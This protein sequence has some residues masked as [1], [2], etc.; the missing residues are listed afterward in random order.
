MR[1]EKTVLVLL[2]VFFLSS[3]RGSVLLND[4]KNICSENGGSHVLPGEVVNLFCVVDNT[5]ARGGN[6]LIW[7]TPVSQIGD[8]IHTSLALYQSNSIFSSTANFNGSVADSKLTFTTIQSLDNKVVTCR[9]SLG[10]LKSCTLLIY[11]K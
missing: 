6:V 4:P 9:D 5:G 8:L 2:M 1:M 10:N 11:S 3:G 7:N